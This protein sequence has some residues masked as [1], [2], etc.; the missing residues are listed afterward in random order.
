MVH[1]DPSGHNELVPKNPETLDNPFVID[2]VR[3]RFAGQ[4]HEYNTPIEPG[5]LF[6]TFPLRRDQVRSTE[7][8]VSFVAKDMPMWDYFNLPNA[9]GEG[10]EGQNSG[11]VP[12][13][14]ASMSIDCDWTAEGEEIVDVNPRQRFRYGFR[15]ARV[16]MGWSAETEGLSIAV[17][18]KATS[19]YVIAAYIGQEQNGV[20]F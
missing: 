2:T 3:G 13:L 17:T 15:H 16:A 19:H 14:P 4:V 12:R 7:S 11:G 10:P 6:W 5:G 20:F 18:E 8:T 9:L 1:S